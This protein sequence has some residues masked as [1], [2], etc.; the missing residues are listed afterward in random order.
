MLSF[1]KGREIAQFIKGK[2]KGKNK[3]KGKGNQKT[4]RFTTQFFHSKPSSTSS[5][6]RVQKQ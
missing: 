5:T 3:G 4:T 1:T 6:S 2:N